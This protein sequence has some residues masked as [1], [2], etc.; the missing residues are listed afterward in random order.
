MAL[1]PAGPV[2]QRR[3]S[4]LLTGAR[5]VPLSTAAPD[6]EVDVRITDGVV[7]EVGPRLRP[8]GEEVLAADGRWLIPG[9]W[10]HH[11]HVVQWALARHRLELAPARSVE[12]ALRVVAAHLATLPGGDETLVQGLGHRSAMWSRQPTVPELDAVSGSHPVV[13]VS[14]DGHHAWMNGRALAMLGLPARDGV[15]EERE[16]FEA[17]PRLAAIP[18]AQPLEVESVRQAVAHAAAKGVVGIVDLEF[19]AS[20]R[21][22]P[23]RIAEGIDQ[24]SVRASCYPERLDDAIG[25]GL[26]SGEPLPGGAG[27]VT[28]GPLKI[29]SDGSLSTRTAYCCEQY[30]DANPDRPHGV[31]NYPADELTALLRRATGHGLEVAVHALGDAAIDQAL[32]AVEQTGAH[33]SL[34]HLQLIRSEDIPRVAALRL[35]ASVQP[36]HLLDDRDVTMQCWPDRH[37]RCFAF[38]SLARA[39]VPLALG[40]DAPV[41]PLDPWLAM[42]AAVHRSCDDR[43]PWN[44]AEALTPRQALAASTDGQGTIAAGSRGDVV[45]LEADP[46]EPSAHSADAAARLRGMPVAHTVVA[47]RVSA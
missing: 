47:G 38:A 15:V 6:A 10:D 18:G 40:S 20:Y 22:W 46:L 11:V 24:I 29:I 25:A 17:Y 42:A 43:P 7:S 34:E 32:T 37:D 41:A 39:G 5:L 12:D 45:L 16:W 21:Q 44:H 9:L 30:V 8:G 36:A 14:G 2:P 3:G 33:G 28:M 26:R 23:Q 13:L 27:L 35:R 19:D 4:L 31:Q 1:P